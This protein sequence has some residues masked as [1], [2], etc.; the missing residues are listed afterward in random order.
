MP[1]LQDLTG[2]IFGRWLVVRRAAS[3]KDHTYWF[4]RCACGTEG[5]VEAHNLQSL[6]PL[7]RSSSCGCYQREVAASNA[8]THGLSRTVPM[9]LFWEAKKRAKKAGLPFDIEPKDVVIPEYC[10]LLGIKIKSGIGVLT[11]SSPSVDRIKPDGG[12][13]KGNV[14]VISYRANAIKSNATL[15]ELERLAA[16]LRSKLDLR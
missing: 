14:W 4:C 2:R 16:A 13:V 10:P 7:H 15:N 3:R 6:D 1:K 12:Y 5:D 8:T 9:I 11:P